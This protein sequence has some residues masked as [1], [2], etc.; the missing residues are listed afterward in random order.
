MS[1]LSSFLTK[2]LKALKLLFIIFKKYLFKQNSEVLL[3]R[4][5]EHIR[6]EMIHLQI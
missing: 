1:E 6:R 5:L 4:C 3:F 2:I